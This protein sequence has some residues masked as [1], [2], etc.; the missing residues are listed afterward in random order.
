LFKQHSQR[1]GHNPLTQSR[2]HSTTNKNIFHALI[3]ARSS[4]YSTPIFQVLLNLI[5]ALP[6]LPINLIFLAVFHITSNICLCIW[7]TSLFS[8]SKQNTLPF[9]K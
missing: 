7:A 8:N 1:G 2:H 3:L 6:S 4:P 5:S 9:S